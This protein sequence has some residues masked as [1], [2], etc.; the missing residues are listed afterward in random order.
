MKTNWYKGIAGLAIIAFPLTAFA[1]T[2]NFTNSSTWTAPAG[3]TTVE[4]QVWA[5]GG[6]GGVGGSNDNGGGGGGGAY[7]ETD[8]VSVT[9]GN[10][11]NVTVGQGGIPV[12]STFTSINGIGSSFISSTTVFAQGGIGGT[13]FDGAGQ[14]GSSANGFGTIKHSGGNASQ[15][16]GG[17]GGAGTTGDGGLPSG[18]GSVGGLGTSVGGGNGANIGSGTSN[19]TTPANASTYGGGGGGTG[20]ACFTIGSSGARGEVD[21]TYTAVTSTPSYAAV[22]SGN[23]KVV[24]GNSNVVIK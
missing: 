1:T 20:A 7:S 10:N 18:I 3:V 5:D 4:A 19:C 11:Y 23:S 14:G 6:A 13:E 22:V 2:V 16:G 21:L 15:V 24:I 8:T 12:L 17:G 9:P